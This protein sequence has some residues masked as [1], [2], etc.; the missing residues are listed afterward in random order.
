[1]KTIRPELAEEEGFRVRFAQEVAAARRVSGVFTAAVVESDA[2]AD[3]PWLATAF[4]PAPSLR[5]LVEQCGPLP[6]PS[7]RWLAAACAE[8]LESIHGAGLVHMDLKPSNVLVATDGA[9]VIDFG[10]ARAAARVHFSRDRGAIGTPAYMAPEQARDVTQA[11][12]ASDI[13][14][15][16]GTLLYAATGH[17]PYEGDTTAD[18]LVRLATEPPD[19]SGLPDELAGLVIPC[20]DRSPRQ[21]PSPARLLSL[22]GEFTEP[23]HYLPEAALAAIEHYRQVAQQPT[24]QPQLA[25]TEET[26]PSVPG[27]PASAKPDVPAPSLRRTW[28]QLLHLPAWAAWATAGGVLVVIGA[29]LGATLSSPGGQA[30]NGLGPPPGPPPVQLGP[31]CAGGPVQSGKPSLCVSSDDGTPTTV[32]TV[33]GS[34]FKAG[35]PVP[36]TLVFYPP[37]AQSG[38]PPKPQRLREFTMSAD[39]TVNLGSFQQLGLY[40]VAV[41]VPA[42]TPSIQ[43]RVDP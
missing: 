10:V 32:F 17:P 20:L 35:A 41:A 1:M 24:A 38:T 7:V 30:S 19:L 28:T 42:D 25:E 43:F 23:G 18:V 13:F 36:L 8:A 3:V 6:P 39:G 29:I 27:L 4:V 22:L 26:A 31:S 2:D 15:L 33:R 40:V 11:S 16:G 34:G 9:R 37:P 21:R 12:G 14:S 5:Q